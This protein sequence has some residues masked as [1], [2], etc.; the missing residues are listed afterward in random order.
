MRTR[1]QILASILENPAYVKAVSKVPEEERKMIE[2]ELQEDY[3][4][5]LFELESLVNRVK[6]DVGLRTEILN[7]LK[8]ERAL[9]NPSATKTASE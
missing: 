6:N 1:E 5:V 2:D 3:V 7:A 4:G 9:F 8:E